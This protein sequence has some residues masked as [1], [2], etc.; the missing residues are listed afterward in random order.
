MRIKNYEVAITEQDD[1]TYRVNFNLCMPPED[2]EPGLSYVVS[3]FKKRPSPEGCK[4]LLA[5]LMRGAKL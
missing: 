5:T 2:A 1:G 3:G 4:E